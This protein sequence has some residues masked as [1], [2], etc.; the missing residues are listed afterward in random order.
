LEG[1]PELL[2]QGKV[3][4]AEV[5]YEMTSDTFIKIYRNEISAMTAYTQK[6]VKFKVSISDMIKLKKLGAP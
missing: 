1:K 6:L 3:E 4:T 2:L 5:Q